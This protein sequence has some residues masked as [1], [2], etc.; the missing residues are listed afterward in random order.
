MQRQPDF[1]AFPT[2]GTGRPAGV[3]HNAT[4]HSD[5]EFKQVSA[6]LGWP[7][8]RPPFVYQSTG[9]LAHRHHGTAYRVDRPPTGVA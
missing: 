4:L 8:S 1:K 6:V 9:Y 2:P 3:T 5:I 7:K